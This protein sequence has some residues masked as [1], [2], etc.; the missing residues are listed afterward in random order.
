MQYL[1]GNPA[2]LCYCQKHLHLLHTGKLPLPELYV[3]LS[4]KTRTHIFKDNKWFDTSTE[5][6]YLVSF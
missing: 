6:F 5:T 3:S 2:S 4:T 1:H